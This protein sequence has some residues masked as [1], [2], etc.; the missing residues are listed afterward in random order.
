MDRNFADRKSVKLPASEIRKPYRDYLAT[1][2]GSGQVGCLG[3]D[4]ELRQFCSLGAGAGLVGPGSLDNDVVKHFDFGRTTNDWDKLVRSTSFLFKWVAGVQCCG[5]QSSDMV[6]KEM[7]V[8]FWMRVS[9]LATNK[10]AA[11]G[12]LKHLSPMQHSRYPDMLVVVGRVSQ[13]FQSLFQ[14]EYLPILM[15]TTRTAW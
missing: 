5:N 6:A 14:K 11:A 10:A 3:A 1:Y 13:G 2:L 12:K 7:A 8:N 15:S 9:M 4:V